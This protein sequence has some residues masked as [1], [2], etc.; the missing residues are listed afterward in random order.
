MSAEQI[1]D[2]F[3]QPLNVGDWVVFASKRGDS[4]L[5]MKGRVYAIKNGL[6][7]IETFRK[8]YSRDP[9]IDVEA[10]MKLNPQKVSTDI[11]NCMV[12]KN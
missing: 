7:R 9:I 3:G 1:V 4:A 5:L 8:T 10:E 6:A 12:V 11:Y 2:R